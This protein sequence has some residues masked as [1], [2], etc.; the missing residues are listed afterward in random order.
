MLVSNMKRIGPAV[1]KKNCERQTDRLPEKR[2]KENK[3]KIIPKIVLRFIR[4]YV[5]TK[6]EENQTSTF[7][8]D[9]CQTDKQSDRTTESPKIYLEN[10]IMLVSL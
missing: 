4:N 3:S 10:V 5:G 2:S 9:P 6:N 1:S 7:V 8:Q